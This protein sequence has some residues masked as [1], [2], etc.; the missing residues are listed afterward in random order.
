MNYL[1]H[2]WFEDE[3]LEVY[4][5]HEHSSMIH[6]VDGAFEAIGDFRDGQ[7]INVREVIRVNRNSEV[8]D[9]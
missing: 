2:E 5:A 3:M 6:S 9:G 1:T 4:D 8:H 7:L